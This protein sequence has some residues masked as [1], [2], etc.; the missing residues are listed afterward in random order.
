MPIEM[1]F[2]KI[3]QLLHTFR[4]RTVETLWRIMQT[5]PDAVTSSDASNCIRHVQ[6][7]LDVD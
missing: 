6:Y 3:K 1:V 5:V 7:T 4:I 2:S